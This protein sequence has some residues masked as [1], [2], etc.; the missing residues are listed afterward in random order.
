[1]KKYLEWIVLFICFVLLSL[2]TTLNKKSNA[3]KILRNASYTVGTITKYNER[4]SKS[5]VSGGTLIPK[6]TPAYVEFSYRFDG[7][8][9]F[10]YYSENSFYIPEAGIK[11]NEKYVVVLERNNPKKS[12]VLFNYQIIDSADFTRYLQEFKANPPNLEQLRKMKNE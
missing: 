3:N 4:Q 10:N 1:M 12:F 11:V 5:Q 7:L 2:L 9:L 6:M 8:L